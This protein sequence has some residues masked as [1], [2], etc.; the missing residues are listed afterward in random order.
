MGLHHSAEASPL[1]HAFQPVNWFKRLP[2]PAPCCGATT[3][4]VAPPTIYGVEPFPTIYGVG[5]LQLGGCW[6]DLFYGVN[7]AGEKVA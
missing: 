5:P 2:H 7:T 3:Y 6:H 4:G 1:N